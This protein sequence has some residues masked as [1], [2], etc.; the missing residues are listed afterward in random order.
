MITSRRSEIISAPFS[1]RV[2]RLEVSAGQ[3]VRKDDRIALLDDTDLRNKIASLK[4][5]EKAAHAQAGVG[6]SSAAFN[7]QKLKN[8]EK[9]VKMGAAPRIEIA[10]IKAEMNSNGASGAAAAAQ[11]LV[12]KE[13][14]AILE[15]QAARAMVVA[16]LEGIVM[17]VRTKD[18]AVIQSGEAIAR[19]FDPGDLIV[20][21]S[22][23]KSE[24][25]KLKKGA[26][27]E[28][29]IEGTDRRIWAVIEHFADEEAPINY[30]LV[31]ADLDDS[32]LLPD[33]VRLASVAKV[34]LADIAGGKS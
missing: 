7:R 16:P 13:E 34:K 21:F 5:Q 24:R 33:E 1:G 28:L 4:A 10:Q 9:L 25:N 31:V 17:M 19:V 30:T 11:G 12:S 3:R 2:K 32:K 15:R 26:R 20:R 14:R 8:V 23:P 18:G 27:V 6:G 22:V 29:A